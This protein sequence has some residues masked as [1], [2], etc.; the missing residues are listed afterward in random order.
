MN[1][2][3]HGTERGFSLIELLV[4]IVVV[5]ILAAIAMQSMSGLV[6]DMRRVKTEREMEMLAS[7]IAGDPSVMQSGVR[8]EFGY[9]GD[10]GAFP[11]NL[12]A[13]VSNPG[14]STWDGPYI[15]D[16]IAEDNNGFKLDAWGAAYQYT[17][18]VTITSTGSGSTMTKTIADASSDYLDNTFAG[19]VLD[20]SGGVPG[21]VYRDSVYIAIF[22]PDG[23][24]TMTS[25]YV[26]PDSAGNFAIP[27][28]PAGRH[29]LEL[30]FTPTVDTLVR[31]ATVLPR[32]N[33]AARYK[34]A[35]DYF[36]GS[37]SAFGRRCELIIVAARVPDDLTDFPLLLTQLNLPSEMLDA[38]GTH[39]ADNGGGDIRF[40]LD[41]NGT[42]SLPCEVVDFTTNSNPVMAEAEIWVN[43]PSVSAGV[44]TSIWVW[45]DQPGATQPLPDDPGGAFE[46]WD[47]NYVVVQHLDDNPGGPAPQAIDATRNGNNG[48]SYGGMGSSD[49]VSGQI[50]RAIDFDGSNDYLRIPAAGVTVSDKAITMEGWMYLRDATGRVNLMQRGSNYALWEIRSGGTPYNV[51]YDNTWRKFNYGQ[52]ATWF[53]DDWHYVVCTYDGTYVRSYIDGDPDETAAYSS[54][55]NPTASNYDM[56]IGVNAGWNDSYYQGRADEIRV[57]RVVRSAAYVKAQYN[58]HDSPHTFVLPQSPETP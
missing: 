37:T 32:H 31:Y 54:D 10:I 57:S 13:L 5:G 47:S 19:R 35:A 34:F 14:F 25:Q 29:R 41:R 22:Y 23:S 51:F 6:V 48:T 49:L 43:V 4:V 11:P 33:G 2:H 27:D 42:V 55:L 50:G 21:P 26:N 15:P 16:G 52:P 45:Y 1:G 30:V 53:L 8:S 12:D 46:V 38:D 24:G 58:N 3:R 20:A 17:G 28:L 39:A 56:G 44:N 9:V 36:G 40:T 7:A 18:G